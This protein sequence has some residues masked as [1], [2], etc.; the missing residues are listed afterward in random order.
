M[1]ENQSNQC[2]KRIGLVIALIALGLSV[3]GGIAI[4]YRIYVEGY[5]MK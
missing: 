3:L 4:A 5:L 1:M 2:V